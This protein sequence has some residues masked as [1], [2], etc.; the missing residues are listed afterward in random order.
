[1]SYID[2]KKYL[3]LYFFTAALKNVW[4]AK[5]AVK[6]YIPIPWIKKLRKK[7]SVLVDKIYFACKL[8]WWFGMT[9]LRSIIFFIWNLCNYKWVKFIAYASKQSC[10][11]LKS[12]LARYKCMVNY[13]GT[14]LKKNV[15]HKRHQITYS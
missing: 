6:C 4:C 3:G 9:I 12:I 11:I 15:H 5:I 13:K 10:K 8:L 2:T 1:M 14:L 7:N